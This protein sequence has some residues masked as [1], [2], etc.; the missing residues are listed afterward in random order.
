MVERTNRK[1]L[2]ILRHAVDTTQEAWQD[3]LSQVAASINGSVNGST[4][5]TPHYIIFG[6]DKRLP[7]DL[8]TQRPVPVY[9]VDD[10]AKK[11]LNVFTSIHTYMREKLQ[12]PR[13]EMTQR[14]HQRAHG[15]TIEIGDSVMK[16]LPGRQ[17]KIAPK[18]SGP[19]LV[20]EKVQGN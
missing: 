9:S 4:G 3:W 12:A 5:K 20:L 14:Q 18:F 16:N 17:S 11:Q 8:L 19:H 10:Y 13:A 6:C 7:Y 15:T 1:I 2:E